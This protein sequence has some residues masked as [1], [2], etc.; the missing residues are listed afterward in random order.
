MSRPANRACVLTPAGRGAVAVVA[1]AGPAAAK[2]V[3]ACFRAANGRRLH[4]QPADRIVFGHWE[5]GDHREEVI[6]VRGGD[7]LEIHCHGGVA[8]SGRIIAALEAGGCSIE[9]WQEWIEAAA[10][11]PIAAEAEI[12]L[13]RATTRRA[14]AILLEQR[15]GALART[16]LLVQQQLRRGDLEDARRRLTALLE[17]APLGLHLTQPWQVAIAGRPNVGK[18]SLINALVGYQRAIVFD[19]PGTTRDVLTAETAVDGWPVRLTDAAGIR[20]TSDPLEAEGVSRARRQLKEADLV[21]WVLDAV[22]LGA[23]A[24]ADPRAAAE[25]ELLAEFGDDAVVCMPVVVVN[26][27]DLAPEWRSYIAD[28]VIATSALMGDG[29]AALLAAIAQRLVPKSPGPEE[30]VPFTERQVHLME[31]ALQHMESNDAAAA[32]EVL[33]RLPARSRRA[34]TG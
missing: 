23:T 2:V 14:A 1:A 31:R 20:A 24:E 34:G 18:S 33:A 29:I 13:A 10:T 3:D 19:Q 16:V 28:G 30:A 25:R 27:V 15:H 17:R 26:K 7:S 9:P 5:S 32:A 11:C 22:T 6:V 4:E 12:A 21:L 8:A